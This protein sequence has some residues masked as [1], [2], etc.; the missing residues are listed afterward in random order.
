[1]QKYIDKILHD[2][3]MY[4]TTLLQIVSAPSHLIELSI[5]VVNG[6]K[7]TN[8]NITMFEEMKTIEDTFFNSFEKI[9]SNKIESDGI[10]GRYIYSI[11]LQKKLNLDW[12]L[13][14]N[15]TNKGWEIFNSTEKFYTLRNSIFHMIKAYLLGWNGNDIKQLPP[16]FAH[17][18][19]ITYEQI[20]EKFPPRFIDY[21][22][23]TNNKL[24]LH[25][26]QH[27]I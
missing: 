7:G 16:T 2:Q 6:Y 12:D 23:I 21:M 19:Y 25:R 15:Y 8:T 13:E 26:I 22:K 5:E 3:W 4:L 10:R 14:H 1:M 18:I 17:N 24:E 27:M 9:Y 20:V 11:Y